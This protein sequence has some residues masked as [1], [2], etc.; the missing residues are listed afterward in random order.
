MLGDDD[1][2]L[3]A[4]SAF[5][6]ADVNP[7]RV[8]IDATASE[9]IAARYEGWIEAGISVYES[10]VG[11]ALPVLTTLQDLLATGDKVT[12]IRWC[13]SGTMAHTLRNHQEDKAFSASLA[14]A[15]AAGF[16]E[17]DVR[18]DLSGVD[19]A[20]KVVIPREA[21]LTPTWRTPT[22][23]PSSP[24]EMVD[25]TYV[26]DPAGKAAAVFADLKAMG[27][28][29]AMDERLAAAKA[30][31][32]TCAIKLLPTGPKESLFR[33]KENE[34]LVSFTTARYATAPSS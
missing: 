22:P 34:N 6:E 31:G 33:L 3:D 17:P 13:L 25:K 1:V 18:E 27:V 15:Y 11:A 16:T 8:I 19:M 28:D 7:Q 23:S 21:G 4:F 2:D 29:A 26:A 20:R 30:E 5:V 9:D 32:N 14:E 24:L 10:S 12:E